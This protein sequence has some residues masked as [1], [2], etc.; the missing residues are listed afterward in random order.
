MKTTTTYLPKISEIRRIW[1]EIDA[2]KYV[3]GRLA[4]RVATLLRGKHKPIF[5]P[6]MDLGDFVVI[7]NAG[8][9]NVTGRKLVQKKYFRASG[10]PGGIRQ[11]LLRDLLLKS[12]EKV[13]RLAVSRM[14][15]ANRLRKLALRRLKVVS[16]DKHKFRIDKKV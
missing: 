4:S 3:L 9:V 13:I 10:Y 12:P 15:P 1:Y 5:T 6:F 2:S 8:K 14:L 7:I 16:D 11:V